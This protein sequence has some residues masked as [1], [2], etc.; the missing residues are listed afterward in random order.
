MTKVTCTFTWRSNAWL[1]TSVYR[2]ARSGDPWPV[3]ASRGIVIAEFHIKPAQGGRPRRRHRKPAHRADV[4]AARCVRWAAAALAPI[5]LTALAVGAGM[6][7]AEERRDP[8]SPTPDHRP[9]P[10]QA[11]T[12]DGAEDFSATDLEIRRDPQP[13]SRSD[14]RGAEPAGDRAVRTRHPAAKRH[15]RRSGSNSPGRTNHPARTRSARPKHVRLAPANAVQTVRAAMRSDVNDPGYC[16]AWSRQQADIPARY[17][18]AATAWR[19]ANGKRRGGLH[20]PPGAAVYWT[21]GTHGYGH[22]AIS[23][24]HGRVRSSDAGGAGRVSTVPLSWISREWGLRY[25]GWADSINGYTIPGVG[26]RG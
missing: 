24:G 8:V 21:G 14:T 11:L 16:L 15:A 6:A 25:A 22:I 18:D 19:H 5:T 2:P 20:P 3:P 17:S 13:I 1:V 7:S 23:V 10:Q 26:R 12:G 9:L 4:P